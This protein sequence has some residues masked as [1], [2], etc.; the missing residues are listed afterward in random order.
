TIV[1]KEVYN[2]APYGN[3]I[4]QSIPPNSA[5]DQ[6]EVLE[7]TV[8]LYLPVL[9]TSSDEWYGKNYMELIAKVDEWNYKGANIHAGPW[10]Q[11]E[12]HP[13]LEKGKIIEYVCADVNG[14]ELPGNGQYSRGCERPL[15]LNAKIGMKVSLGKI[16]DETDVKEPEVINILS[17]T[18]MDVLVRTTPGATVTITTDNAISNS[19]VSDEVGIATIKIDLTSATSITIEARLDGYTSSYNKIDLN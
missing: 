14:N 6:G 19:G 12:Y 18:N 3:V 17:K 4:A 11:G 5:V 16:G 7:L 2:E 15:P 10:I 9:Q 1:K 8:S 13:K